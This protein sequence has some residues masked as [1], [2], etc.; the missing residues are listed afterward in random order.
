MTRLGKRNGFAAPR[1]NSRSRKVVVSSRFPNS[2]PR[3]SP[4]RAS[5]SSVGSSPASR[6]ASRQAAS[7]KSETRSIRRPRGERTWARAST[8]GTSAAGPAPGGA[9]KR[10][11]GPR[12]LSPETSAAQKRSTPCPKALSTPSPVTATGTLTAPPARRRGSRCA[13]R[14]HRKSSPRRRAARGGPPPA[15]GRGRPTRDRDAAG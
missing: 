10:R 5:G 2:E 14:S 1:A 7:A 15:R 4:V 8:A 6:R 13:R 11:I 12:P 3:A 9:V